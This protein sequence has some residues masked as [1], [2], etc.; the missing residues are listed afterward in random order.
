MTLTSRMSAAG[1]Q[2]PST[3]S[4]GPPRRAGARRRLA[5]GTAPAAAV[6]TRSASVGG[7]SVLLELLHGRVDR[8]RVGQE[9]LEVGPLALALGAAERGRGLVRH[10]EAEHRGAG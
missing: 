8:R 6:L 3:V 2:K 7:G 5:T 10:V 1:A 9:R 4:P